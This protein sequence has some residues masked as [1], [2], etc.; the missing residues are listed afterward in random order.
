MV[1]SRTPLTKRGGMPWSQKRI[2]Y[3]Y[4]MISSRTQRLQKSGIRQTNS[5]SKILMNIF[6]CI[7]THA[8]TSPE[9]KLK[10]RKKGK[11]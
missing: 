4:T 3:E 8:H 1:A 6:R 11:K 7:L 5:E 10:E 9:E 2:T